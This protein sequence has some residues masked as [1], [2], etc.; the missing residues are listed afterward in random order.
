[1]SGVSP[2]ESG[3][4][5]SRTV[6]AT[7]PG[8]RGRREI[9]VERH[10]AGDEG[11]EPVHGSTAGVGAQASDQGDGE[12]QGAAPGVPPPRFSRRP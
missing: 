6:R 8:L 11:Q 2:A 7:G 3:A 5:A 4:V 12:H 9:V 10:A 1:M